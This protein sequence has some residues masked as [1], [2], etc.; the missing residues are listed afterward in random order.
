MDATA[1]DALQQAWKGGYADP[2]HTVGK[3][4]TV[5]GLCFDADLPTIDFMVLFAA[6]ASVKEMTAIPISSVGT[7]FRFSMPKTFGIENFWQPASDTALH[8]K[9]A[10]IRDCYTSSVPIRTIQGSNVG[11]AGPG[12]RSH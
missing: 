5:F 2:Y 12:P 9:G 4:V 3:P 6:M 1:A 7:P 11:R 8:V 10:S